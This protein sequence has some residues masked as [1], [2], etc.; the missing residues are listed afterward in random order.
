MNAAGEGYQELEVL[1]HMASHADHPFSSCVVQLLDHFEFV[2]PQEKHLCLV[3]ELQWQDFVSFSR[4]YGREPEMR[5]RLIKK[6]AK[7]L[8]HALDYL[9]ACGVVHN[10]IIYF[11]FPLV[12]TFFR[13]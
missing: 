7:Q 1:R 13:F 3:L 5:L 9:E 2:G 4:G 11:M 6:V 8:L 12:L 10:G